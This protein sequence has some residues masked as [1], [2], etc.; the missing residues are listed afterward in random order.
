MVL[1]ILFGG[2]AIFLIYGID[3]WPSLPSFKRT[4][5]PMGALILG[6]NAPALFVDNLRQ[7]RPDA[8]RKGLP[9]APDLLALMIGRAPVCTPV[10]HA[11]IVC[12]LLIEKK[13]HHRHIR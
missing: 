4:A 9:D 6:Y 12:R 5:F 2:L 8:T 3:M 13:K 1:P 10:T 7:K 11:Q